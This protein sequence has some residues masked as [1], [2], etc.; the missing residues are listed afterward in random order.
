MAI[1]HIART[2]LG[3]QISENRNQTVRFGAP[4]D[5]PLLGARRHRRPPLAGLSS[6]DSVAGAQREVDEAA[7]SVRQFLDAGGAAESRRRGFT[8]LNTSPAV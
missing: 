6:V 7:A 1:G 5:H 4:A 2:Q 3:T 8:V